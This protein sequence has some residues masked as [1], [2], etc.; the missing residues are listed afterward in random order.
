MFGN[1]IKSTYCWHIHAAFY[2]LHMS[3]MD[4]IK[5][6]VGI[7][8]FFKALDIFTIKTFDPIYWGLC[9]TTNIYTHIYV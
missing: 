3:V 6:K 8:F 1:K 9:S 2:L 7:P 4:K 5:I